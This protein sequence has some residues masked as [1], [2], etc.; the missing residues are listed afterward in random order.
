MAN[1]HFSSSFRELSK[2]RL[3]S[4]PLLSA[5]NPF[6]Y[7]IESIKRSSP[8]AP[9]GVSGQT[10]FEII[11]GYGFILQK[12]LSL[13]SFLLFLLIEQNIFV[14]CLVLVFL[15]S[16]GAIR[17]S[18]E[19]SSVPLVEQSKHKA[20]LWFCRVQDEKGNQ[21]EVCVQTV[22]DIIVITSDR[23]CCFVLET[24]SPNLCM[25]INHF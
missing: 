23:W 12:S 8:G 18:V 6:L 10:L 2:C 17:F 14:F 13:L 19:M 24:L 11:Y 16:V 25:Q 15:L 22:T 1:W 5:Q 21:T 20:K 9:L 3:C 7:S 4:N